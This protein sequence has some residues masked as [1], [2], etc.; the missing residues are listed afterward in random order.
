VTTGFGVELSAVGR[1]NA[2]P[3][4]SLNVGEP[5]REAVKLGL[6]RGRN[7]AAIWQDLVSE[8]AI[9]QRRLIKPLNVW[10]ANSAALNLRHRDA[11][12]T[13]PGQ[14][15]KSNLAG[16]RWFVIRRAANIDAPACSD[17]AWL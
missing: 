13:G 7:V 2:K 16:A 11:I 15:A 6:G 8:N 14:E 5:F 10:S 9:L 1:G 4:S 17:D 12:V 3:A